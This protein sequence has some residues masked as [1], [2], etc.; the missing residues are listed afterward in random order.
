MTPPTAPSPPPPALAAE[1]TTHGI[2]G[3]HGFRAYGT[4]DRAGEQLVAVWDSASERLTAVVHGQELGPRRTGA[5]GAV[6]SKP[7]RAPAAPRAAGSD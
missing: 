1:G 7:W 5:I 3:V 2:P 6:R 4:A